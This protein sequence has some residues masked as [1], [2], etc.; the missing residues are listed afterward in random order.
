MAQGIDTAQNQP[1]LCSRFDVVREYRP[2]GYDE[3]KF[4]A[5]KPVEGSL[6]ET[7]T[8]G[9]G[10]ET[11]ESQAAEVHAPTRAPRKHACQPSTV[12]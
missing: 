10:P 12:P 1:L 9:S 5:D 8:S 3:F 7:P 4:V 11:P 2:L 6:G